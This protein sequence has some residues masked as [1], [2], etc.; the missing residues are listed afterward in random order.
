MAPISRNFQSILAVYLSGLAVN[1]SQ[2]ISTFTVLFFLGRPMLEKIE[3]IKVKYG[4]IEN[5]SEKDGENL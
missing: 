3:R 5:N 4:I 2:G 1:I